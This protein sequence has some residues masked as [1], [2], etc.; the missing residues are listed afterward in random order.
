MT[1]HSDSALV[2]KVQRP[3]SPMLII[4]HYRLISLDFQSM[5]KKKNGTIGL[6]G[7]PQ[8]RVLWTL[9]RPLPMEAS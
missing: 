5:N 4:L 9:R 1:C 6:S 8:L 2:S 7:L 3:T